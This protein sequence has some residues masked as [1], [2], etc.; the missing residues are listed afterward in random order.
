MYTCKNLARDAELLCRLNISH[1]NENQPVFSKNIQH[2]HC[3]HNYMN[4]NRIPWHIKYGH[5]ITV[6]RFWCFPQKVAKQCCDA[7]RLECTLVLLNFFQKCLDEKPWFP[8]LLIWFI[9]SMRYDDDI[10]L[11]VSTD[12]FPWSL[13]L[14]KAYYC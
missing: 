5:L 13:P 9:I 6:M 11:Y 7:T 8:I 14:P 4:I 10:S 12:S 1:N 2:N 3:L